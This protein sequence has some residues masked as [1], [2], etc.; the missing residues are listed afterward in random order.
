MQL[1]CVILKDNMCFFGRDFFLFPLVW[2]LN[3]RYLIRN[4]HEWLKIL[5][6]NRKQTKSKNHKKHGFPNDKTTQHRWIFKII[7]FKFGKNVG[8]FY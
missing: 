8:Y 2:S 3:S 6:L 1:S 4:V 5:N 7:Q